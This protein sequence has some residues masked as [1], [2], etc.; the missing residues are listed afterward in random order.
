MSK[1][2]L[3]GDDVSRI[4][5]ALLRGRTILFWGISLYAD[6]R[7]MFREAVLEAGQAF[8]LNGDKTKIMLCRGHYADCWLLTSAAPDTLDNDEIRPLV[9][10]WLRLSDELDWRVWLTSTVE[11]ARTHARDWS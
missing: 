7:Q 5:G 9:D 8:T 2:T 4:G 11:R 3:T 6:D 10:L 1:I